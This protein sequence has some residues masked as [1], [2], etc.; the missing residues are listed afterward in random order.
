LVALS[1]SD[2]KLGN[3]AMVNQQAANVFGYSKTE[4]KTIKVNDIMPK[5]FADQ[6]DNYLKVFLQNKTKKVNSDERKLFGKNKNGYA[7]P[8]LLQ[9]QRTVSSTGD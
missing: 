5:I 8:I 2:N 7:F 9:L 4:F 1:L 3:I 6:H